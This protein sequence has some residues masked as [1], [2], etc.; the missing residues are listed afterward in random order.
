MGNT[1]VGAAANRI[2]ADA[3]SFASLPLPLAQRIFLALPVDTRITASFVCRAW[4]TMLADPAL[5]TRLDLSADCGVRCHNL[6]DQIDWLVTEGSARAC[7]Q[8]SLP[9]NSRDFPCYRET[10]LPLLAAHAGSMREL[11]QQPR[12]RHSLVE[13]LQQRDF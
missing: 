11:G 3:A 12:E 2:S 7:G 8:L 9:C 1:H 13:R 4:K 6:G 5:W 10:L